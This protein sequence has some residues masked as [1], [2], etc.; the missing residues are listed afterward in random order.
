MPTNTHQF[1]DTPSSK[2]VRQTLEPVYNVL[3]YNLRPAN[4]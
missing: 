4:R 2:I 3:I 1:N